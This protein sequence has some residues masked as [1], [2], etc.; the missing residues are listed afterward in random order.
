M[1]F[2]VYVNGLNGPEPQIWYG[3]NTNGEGKAKKY[4]KS[5]S[6]DDSD[7]RTIEELKLAY[8]IEAS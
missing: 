1:K 3:E 5:F 6:L 7:K 8:P 2:F 4:L